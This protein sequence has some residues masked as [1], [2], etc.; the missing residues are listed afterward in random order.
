M[1]MSAIP[2]G[3]YPHPVTLQ[4]VLRRFAPVMIVLLASTAC[5]GSHSGD[6]KAIRAVVNAFLQAYAAG[7]GQKVCSKLTAEGRRSLFSAANPAACERTVRKQSQRARPRDRTRLRSAFVVRVKF[8]G[9]TTAR[10]Y[11]KFP[12]FDA[13]AAPL[14]VRKIGA[15][16]LI[17]GPPRGG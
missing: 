7:D 3:S 5:G 8:T 16:W 2:R 10:A 9:K 1:T 12:T 17:L 14:R 15:R 13:P 11:I 4:A 6:E